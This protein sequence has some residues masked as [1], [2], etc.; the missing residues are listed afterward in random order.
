MS[1]ST[2]VESQKAEEDSYMSSYVKQLERR[3]RGLENERRVVESER[4]RLKREL[5]SLKSEIEKIKSPPLVAATLVDLLPDKK[6][7][8]RSSAGPEFIVEIS[9]FVDKDKLRPGAQVGLNQRTLNIMKILPLKKD[10]LVRGM[11]VEESPDVTYDDIGGLKG[12]IQEIKET[13]ELPLLKFEEI[14][15]IGVEP[16]HGVLLYGP[17]GTGKTLLARA[18]AHETE[19][20]FIRLIGSELVHKFVGEGARI[21][22]EMFDFAREKAPSIV[23]IDEIDA[24]ASRRM[25]SSTSGDREVHRTMMQLLAELDGFEPRGNIKILAATNR[26][27]ILDPALLRPGRFDRRIEFPLPEEEARG[28]IFKI[29]TRGMTL[30]ENID[31][32]RLAKLAENASGADIKAIC[33]EAGMLAI[34]KGQEEITSENFEA[35]ISKVLS[36]TEKPNSGVMF[37]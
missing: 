6:A 17:P 28:A 4:A 7:L 35:A 25:N 2:D 14:K 37:G 5:R 29:H 11:E 27:D 20:T 1:D 36:R 30:S 34:R 3:I 19:A 18:V 23:F 16:P 8:V 26:P 15:E 24:V 31:L 10:P 21:V 13:V 22:R 12:Q 32:E 33:T 9:K